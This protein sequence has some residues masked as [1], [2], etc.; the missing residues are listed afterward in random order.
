MIHQFETH[1]NREA[2]QT[3]LKQNHAHKPFSEKSMDMIYS[4][5]NMEFFEICEIPPKVQCSNCMTYWTKGIVYCTY[6][7]CLRP[8]NK[9][10]KLNKDRF[11]VLSIPNYVIKKGPSHGARHGN[12]EEQIIYHAAL[13][14]SKKAKKNDCESLLDRFLNSPCYRESQINIAWNE[15]H[16]ARYDV[17]AAGYH[18]SFAA[19]AE[20][21]GRQN[22]WVLELNSSGPSGPMNQREDQNQRST[23]W[24]VWQR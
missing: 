1:P 8:S 14:S 6:G 17:I 7:T 13:V 5:G 2:L 18:S 11:D 3:D 21:F 10:R 15:E 24:S 19:T 12:T 9:I 4:M 16:C 20:R 23:V 22:T